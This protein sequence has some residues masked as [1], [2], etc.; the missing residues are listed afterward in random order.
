VLKIDG[1]FA[2]LDKSL[3]L[4]NLLNPDISPLKLSKAPH[5]DGAVAFRGLNAS[6]DLNGSAG[7]NGASPIIGLSMQYCSIVSRWDLIISC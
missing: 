7:D 2:A 3:M 1:V 6:L 4:E 5:P